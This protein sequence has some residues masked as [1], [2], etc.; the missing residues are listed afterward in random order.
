[1]EEK[2]RIEALM[3]T[4]HVAMKLRNGTLR[5]FLDGE[6][7]TDAV[8]TPDVSKAVSPVSGYPEV[9]RAMVREQRLLGAE[10]DCDGWT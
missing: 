4:T 7:V 5:V 9:R 8:R 3:P 6:D 2:E 10:G 1:M